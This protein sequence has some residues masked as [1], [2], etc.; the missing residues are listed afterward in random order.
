[1]IKTSVSMVLVFLFAVS[2][3]MAGDEVKLPQTLKA[4]NVDLVLNGSGM[5]QKK[6]AFVNLD[7]YIGALYLA[8]K[9]SDAKAVLDADEPMAIR[10]HIV[11][12]LISPERMT[13][14][15]NE[16]FVK[17]TNGNTEP[18]KTRITK[19]ISVF[20]DGIDVDDAYDLIYT[21]GNG[22]YITKNG[23]QGILIEGLDFKKALFGIWLCDNPAQQSLKKEMMGL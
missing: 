8:K 4:G 18:I 10:L 20:K 12:K 3:A 5:R 6:I 2:T 11:S 23:K 15:V 7:L 13:E 17:S 19:M 14:S 16:G 9:N 1:M 21:P 22:V